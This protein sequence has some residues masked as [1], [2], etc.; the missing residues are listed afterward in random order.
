MRIETD[1]RT[2]YDIVDYIG[3]FMN[4]IEKIT[5]IIFAVYIIVIQC[6]FWF[7]YFGWVIE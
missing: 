2:Y 4:P 1:K 7:N 6:I 3:D 5:L